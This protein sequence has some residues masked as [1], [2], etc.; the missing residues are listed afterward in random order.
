LARA[1]GTPVLVCLHP[2][3]ILR[4]E[5]SRQPDLRARWVESLR[6]ASPHVLADGADLAADAKATEPAAAAA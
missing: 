5:P 6:R 4:A 1:D 3:A 2:A